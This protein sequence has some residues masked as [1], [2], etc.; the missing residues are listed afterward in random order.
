[1]GRKLPRFIG[2][3]CG[4]LILRQ[5]DMCIDLLR[6]RND[7][8]FHSVFCQNVTHVNHCSTH[9]I[10]DQITKFCVFGY[11]ELRCK[12]HLIITNTYIYDS[13]K[14]F[15]DC[16][17]KCSRPRLT[18]HRSLEETNPISS[19]SNSFGIKFS[20]SSSISLSI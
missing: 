10:T 16:T 19:A 20:A 17:D 15:I 1:M 9:F 2:C 18:G 14:P 11:R 8:I 5:Q 13:G 3:V 7:V 4:V 12:Y 6:R